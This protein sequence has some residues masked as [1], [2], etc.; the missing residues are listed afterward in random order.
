MK[1]CPKI[2]QLVHIISHL[3]A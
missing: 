3:A 1:T 2:L